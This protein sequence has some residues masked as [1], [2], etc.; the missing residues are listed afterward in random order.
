MGKFCILI[1]QSQ[2]KNDY[3]APLV[4]ATCFEENCHCQLETAV[5]RAN[6]AV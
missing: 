2:L 3:G 5:K 4:L 1:R 6:P